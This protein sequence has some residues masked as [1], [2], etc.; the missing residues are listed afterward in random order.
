MMS[1]VLQLPTLVLNKNWMAIMVQPVR[2]ALCKV[3]AETAKIIDPADY[4]AYTWEEWRKL[5][6]LAG[7]AIIPCANGQII[8]APDVIVL[9]NYDQLH[10]RLV[11]FNRRNLFARDKNTCQ[12]CGKKPG[13]ENLSVEHVIPQCQGGKSTWDNCVLACVPCNV[14]KGGRTPK[15]AGMTLLRQ[16]SKPKWSPTFRTKIIKPTW[17]RFMSDLYWN[18]ELEE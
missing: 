7:E 9:Q 11:Q 4:Q 10:A 16:P 15:Q 2:E 6:P 18:I 1:Q 14:R 13:T 17:R 5:T 3:F 12:Y 8:R